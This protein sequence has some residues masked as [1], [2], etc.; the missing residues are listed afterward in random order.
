MTPF[1]GKRN[2]HLTP[3]PSVGLQPTFSESRTETDRRLLS[4]AVAVKA[5]VAGVTTLGIAALMQVAS[6]EELGVALEHSGSAAAF[7]TI[8]V[9]LVLKGR[10]ESHDE[11]LE[12]L[13]TGQASMTTTMNDISTKVTVLYD[14]ESQRQRNGTHTRF[15]DDPL[16]RT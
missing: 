9:W 3:L 11:K 2:R 1:S 7:A 15:D 6:G 13:K 16:D 14:R 8:A 12:N 10:I 5:A 4:I